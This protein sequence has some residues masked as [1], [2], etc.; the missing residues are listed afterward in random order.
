MKNFVLALI[1]MMAMTTG[2]LCAQDYD[3]IYYDASKSTTKTTK[4]VKPAKTVAVY[5]EVPDS[6]KVASSSNYRVERDVDE[7]NR[8]G[9]IY[10]DLGYEVDINGDTIYEDAFANTRRIERFYNPSTSLLAAT[11]DTLLPMVGAILIILGTLAFM[12]LGT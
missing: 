10:E 12:S 4:V 1:G 9:G 8:H 7:Y 6:Y 5:G 11:G 2:S 3:D